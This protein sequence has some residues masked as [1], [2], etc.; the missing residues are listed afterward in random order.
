MGSAEAVAADPGRGVR[1]ALTRYRVIA[2]IVGILLVV[3]F[4]IGLPLQF[5]AGHRGVDRVVGI[6]HGMVFY[7]LYLLATVDLAWRVRMPP[8]RLLLTLV[9]GTVPF[10][11]FVA[12]RET[13]RWVSSRRPA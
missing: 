5:I 6:G 10:V 12:E 1:R 4:C 8:L 3:L 13:T 9:A 7:P 11:S 2:W